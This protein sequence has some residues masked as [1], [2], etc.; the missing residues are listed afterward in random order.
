MRTPNSSSITQLEKEGNILL[1]VLQYLLGRLKDVRPVTHDVKGQAYAVRENGTLGDAV[2]DLAPQFIK[3]TLTLNTLSGLVAAYKAG[4]DDL[5]AR[6]VA[7]SILSPVAVAL[8]SI[9]ADDFG[10]RHIFGAAQHKEDSGFQFNRFYP[11]EEFLIAFRAGFLFNEMA[12]KVQQL[13][14]SLTA[15]SSVEVAD[16][17]MSQMVTV[18]Q[19]A[20]TRSAVQLPPEIPLIPWRTF[21]EVNPVESKFLLR[22]KAV[23]DSLPHIAL[24]EIDGKW[25][26]DTVQSIHDYI[27]ENLPEA[28]VIA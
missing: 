21:R 22:M 26:L 20:V 17:G 10:H 7:F 27:T 12:T 4:L 19:G 18:K 25:K 6:D 11:P 9:K 2:R 5:P 3:P 13:C 23:K 16:D 14:S 1:N 28:T 8:E 15:E 24:F